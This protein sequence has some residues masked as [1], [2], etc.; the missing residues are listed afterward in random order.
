MGTEKK[1]HDVSNQFYKAFGK[2]GGTCYHHFLSSVWITFA[3]S[4]V[5]MQQ[6]WQKK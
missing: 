3:I 1:E 5:I 4:I 6:S 2:H